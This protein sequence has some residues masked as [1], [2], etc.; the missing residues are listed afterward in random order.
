VPVAKASAMA[1]AAPARVEPSVAASVKKP[2][3]SITKVSQEPNV[4][5]DMAVI[6]DTA[7]EA[8]AIKP[9]ARVSAP[10]PTPAP[11]AKAAVSDG[12]WETF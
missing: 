6:K 3:A 9:A 1:P 10:A 2:V 7:R 4:A 8:A 5:R 12:D 11:R